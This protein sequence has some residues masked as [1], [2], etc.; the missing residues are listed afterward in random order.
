MRDSGISVLGRVSWGTHVCAFYDSASDMLEI[1]IPYFRSGLENNEK[2]IWICSG[3]LGTREA[4]DALKAA[5]PDAGRY[6][7]SGQMTVLPYD[8]FYV[9]TWGGFC[10]QRPINQWKNLLDQALSQGYAGLRVTGDTSWIDP[11][12]WESFC[13]YERNLYGAIN[14]E[15]VL[16]VCCYP[17]QGAWVPDVI[18]VLGTHQCALV[19]REHGWEAISWGGQRERYLESLIDGIAEGVLVT[20][21]TGRIL[22]ANHSALNYFGVDTLIDLGH[23]ICELGRRFSLRTES[24]GAALS[25]PAL[26]DGIGTARRQRWFVTN[27]KD[28]C[29]LDLLVHIRELEDAS[30]SSKRYLVLMQDL[31]AVRS[32]ER[33]RDRAV[34]ILA[35]ELRNPLQILKAVIPLIEDS[36][37]AANLRRYVAALKKQVDSLSELTED[38][39][40]A[41]RTGSDSLSMSPRLID[42]SRLVAACVEWLKTLSDHEIITLYRPDLEVPVYVDE[43]R[44]RQILTNIFANAVKYTPSDRRIWI[45]IR[46]LGGRVLIRVEDEGIGIPEGEND[47]IFHPFFRASNSSLAST[48]GMGLGLYISRQLARLHGGDLWAEDR[49]GGGTVMTLSLPLYARGMSGQAYGRA[50][51][52]SGTR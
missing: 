19:R 24:G 5:M 3:S 8:E 29:T 41:F 4:E 13:E 15:R 50:S 28:G 1:L 45:D 38:L 26:F 14:H 34:R 35:H 12:I 17:R 47:L 42:I 48:E 7:S 44:I 30:L 20:D 27:E 39:L 23:N 40:L 6:F 16:V 51:A 49:H 52:G 22:A 11:S 36:H 43:S 37:S 18:Q 32:M 2:C 46:S 31:T 9:D 25:I 10:S 21:E 33:A